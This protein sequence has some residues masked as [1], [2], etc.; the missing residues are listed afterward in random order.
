MGGALAICIILKSNMAYQMIEDW[1]VFGSLHISK[2]AVIVLDTAP[3]TSHTVYLYVFVY[4]KSGCGSTITCSS[5]CKHI[6][7]Y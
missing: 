3:K 2:L 5:G 1:L 7:D 6:A 4:S